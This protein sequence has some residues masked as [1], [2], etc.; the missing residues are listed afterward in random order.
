MDRGGIDR[1][2]VYRFIA[3]A[4]KELNAFIAFVCW[5]LSNTAESWALCQ[6]CDRLP[7]LLFNYDMIFLNI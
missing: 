3:T 2:N 1:N 7:V 5:P 6:L 4:L